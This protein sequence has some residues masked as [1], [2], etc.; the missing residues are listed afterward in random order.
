MALAIDG[1]PKACKNGFPSRG[2]FGSEER[3]AAVKMFDDA[4]EVG[5][6]INYGG[7]EETAYEEEFSEYMGGGFAD[8]VNSGTTALYCAIGALRLPPGSEVVVPPIS[9]PGGCM[10]VAL[11]NLIPVPADAAPVSVCCAAVF[12]SPLPSTHPGI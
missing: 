11:H 5:G 12:N 4:I 6:V 8:G 10:P 7:E 2:L 9:D 3:A 1:G